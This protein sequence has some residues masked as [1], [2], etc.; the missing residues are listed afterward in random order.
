MQNVISHIRQIVEE[1]SLD[2]P[3][4]IQEK[5]TELTTA[6]NALVRVYSSTFLNSDG[7]E[8]ARQKNAEGTTAASVLAGAPEVE[9][10]EG[11]RF[12]KWVSNEDG[13]SPVADVTANAVNRAVVVVDK[14]ALAAK[15][16]E[17]ANTL[18]DENL[19]EADFSPATWQALAQARQNGLAVVQNTE[20]T[21]ADVQKALNDLT[22]AW[23]SMKR[24]YVLTFT[25][26]GSEPKT[27]S[28]LEGTHVSSFYP[29]MET[30]EGYTFD[31]WFATETFEAGSEW[32]S[33]STV[34]GSLSIYAQWTANKQTVTFELDGGIAPKA[35][36]QHR[37]FPMAIPYPLLRREEIITH[38]PAGTAM[39]RLRQPTI[40]KRLLPAISICMRSGPLIAI[41]P[42]SFT[43]KA[44]T[45]PPIPKP[46]MELQ[47]SQLQKR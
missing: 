15:F 25:T 14:S 44:K 6:K 7:E 36:R 37:P 2:T 13:S 16:G 46:M 21:V 17:I 28:A 47:R 19:G 29:E 38:C 22:N 34:K 24:I 9:A 11:Y 30:R 23:T 4:E 43:T 45:I 42:P 5:S 40:L 32:V 41:Q 18:T 8:I 20:A 39:K 1:Q 35:Q 3:A 10:A 33:G 31:G 12:E 27:V 26:D